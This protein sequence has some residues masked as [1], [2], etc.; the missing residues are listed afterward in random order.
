MFTI[1][2]LEILQKCVSFTFRSVDFN[3]IKDT[4]EEF[5]VLWEK[6]NEIIEEINKKG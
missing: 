1:N 3:E 5:E 2:E 6:I 4:E